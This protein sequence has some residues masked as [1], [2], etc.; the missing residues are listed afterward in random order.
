[1]SVINQP[2]K[3]AKWLI[4]AIV[5]LGGLVVYFSGVIPKPVS[6]QASGIPVEV[7]KPVLVEKPDGLMLTAQKADKVRDA[8]R[9]GDFATAAQVT[10]AVLAESKIEASG[11]Y[12][13][14]E[15]MARVVPG[16]D[17]ALLENLNKWAAQDKTSALPYL[18][19]A[20]YLENTGWKVRGGNFIVETKKEHMDTFSDYMRM[21]TVDI[22]TAMERDTNNPY[23]N[24]M[25]LSISKSVHGN[26]D[27]V[28]AIFQ[29]SIKKF[30]D[31]VGLYL[32]RLDS[33]EPRW[34]GSIA[35][36]EKF[37]VKYV[38]PVQDNSPLK[39]LYIEQYASAL[40]TTYLACIARHKDD[41]K[42]YEE[43]MNSAINNLY[44]PKLEANLRKAFG[45]YS[46]IDHFQFVQSVKAQM[47]DI[48]YTS[49]AKRSA[50]KILQLAADVLNADT[51]MTPAQPKA[52]NYLIDELVALTWYN[53]RNFNNAEKK[54]LEA[55]KRIEQETFPTAEA[56]LVTLAEAYKAL[57]S[58]YREAG[59]HEKAITYQ[60]A[61]A[62]AVGDVAD[63]CEA[64]YKNDDFDNAI[65][66]C[67][68]LV[69]RYNDSYHRYWR[70]K[71]YL[72]KGK[73]DEALN[74]FKIIADSED[75]DYRSY[76]AS[77]VTDIY[78]QRQDFAGALA[79]MTAHPHMFDEKEIPKDQLAVSYNNKC[80][81][82]MQLKDY[83]A[84]LESCNMSLKYGDIPDA[85]KKQKDLVEL[86][87][88][89]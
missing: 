42:A 70:A 25:L 22:K 68:L 51:E 56:K 40:N 3:A 80:Y 39:L 21:A 17:N 30:P 41:H 64:Y 46:K 81:F 16:A 77:R 33:L 7:V 62:A 18:V 11:F 2:G 54:F 69:E 10:G 26:S 13:F 49:G 34:G 58:T 29:E 73:T 28:E 24:Y 76:A 48:I 1:M 88:G 50:S 20:K 87:K 8:I 83:K 4:M 63:T 9:K 31:Y 37:M 74:D 52:G 75:R 27:E 47:V 86:V 44:T 66:Q 53:Q 14:N 12:P 55:L 67:G 38:E 15:F 82:Q 32:L 72:S 84:A 65:R 85:V 59:A 45:L 60:N 71:A 6:Q 23:A 57:A 35:L 79:Y 78:N 43:C 19:R 36:Q 61:A 5:L 89:S